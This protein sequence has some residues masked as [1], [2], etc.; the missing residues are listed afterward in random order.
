GGARSR[1]RAKLPANERRVGC[2]DRNPMVK[3]PGL[4]VKTSEPVCE[5]VERPTVS[6]DSTVHEQGATD[7]KTLEAVEPSARESVE[8]ARGSRESVAPAST[9]SR[10]L[11]FADDTPRGLQAVLVGSAFVGFSGALMVGMGI[12]L[13]LYNTRNQANETIYELAVAEDRPVDVAEEATFDDNFATAAT[14]RKLAIGMGASAGVLLAIGLPTLAVGLHRRRKAL[15]NMAVQPV[16][17]PTQ[18]GV[19]LGGRF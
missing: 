10:A 19:T 15:K 8:P 4:A 12:S 1:L 3:L 13:S 6:M 7:P 18:A 2:P 11:P 9:P 16:F 14:Y 17:G 5:P